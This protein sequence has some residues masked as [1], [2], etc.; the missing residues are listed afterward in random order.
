LTTGLDDVDTMAFV[1]RRQRHWEF[2]ASTE[3]DFSP[4]GPGQEAG[5]VVRMNESHYYSIHLTAG[6]AGREVQVRQRIG[7]ISAVTG[8]MAVG[9][10][11]V[12]LSAEGDPSRYRLSAGRVGEP[13]RELLSAGVRP[14]ST[15]VAGGFTGVY[16]GLYAQGKGSPPA[17]F[18]WFDY[19]AVEAP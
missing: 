5:L 19:K 3:V 16:L 7:G 1:G 14:L 9:D 6:E 13:L 8:R 18:D 2:Q 10:G 17:R 4:K 12:V 11:P 15:E